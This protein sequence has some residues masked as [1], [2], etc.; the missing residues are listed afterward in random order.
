MSNKKEKENTMRE[1]VSSTEDM[2]MEVIDT[3]EESIFKDHAADQDDAKDKKADKEEENWSY[4]KEFMSWV[5]P[6]VTAVVIALFIKQFVI[7]NANIPSPSMEKT[8]MTGD[9]LFGFRLAYLFSDPK[10]GDIIIFKYPVEEDPDQKYIKRIIGLPG[11]HVVVKDAKIY[12]NDSKEPLEEDY[13][14]EEWINA[15]GTDHEYVFDI[16]EDSYLVMGDNRNN[17]ADAREWYDIE[18]YGG[19][20]DN[21]I[22]VSRDRILGKA[23]L[24]Y[25]PLSEFGLL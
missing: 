19:K 7:I 10:R 17:S 6:L 13:L 9:D 5:I 20:S 22:Y 16:P 18:L 1:E 21:G 8:I 11:E 25:W 24:I 14:P 4:F 3:R 15:N 12:I 23:V 2:D